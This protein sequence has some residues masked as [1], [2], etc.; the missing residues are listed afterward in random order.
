MPNQLNITPHQFKKG[1]SG[2]PAGRP[3][4]LPE[5]SDIITTALTA[6]NQKGSTAI[7]RIVEAI[8]KK[9]E[10]GDM[11]AAELLLDRAYGKALQAIQNTNVVRILNEA[12]D[13]TFTP[14]E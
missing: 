9:A 7:Q 8:I 4:Q 3:P 6:T 13:N 11:R 10:R 14:P 1:Q 5:L 12:T 2:N